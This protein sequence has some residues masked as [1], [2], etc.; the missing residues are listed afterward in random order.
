MFEDLMRRSRRRICSHFY[1]D[2]NNN[3]DASVFVAGSG[4]SGTS[5]LSNI[6]NHLNEFRYIFEPFAPAQ[7]RAFRHFNV[8]QYLRPSN[9]DS[10]FIEPV[11]ALLEGRLRNQWADHLNR[12]CISKKR[13]IKEIRASLFIK[14]LVTH[15]SEVPIV[16]ILRHPCAVVLSQLKTQWWSADSDYEQALGQSDLVEDFLGT[17]I[18]ELDA[19]SSAFERLIGLWCVENIVPLTQ[20]APNEVH[21]IFYEHLC[22]QPETE[23]RR[24]FSFLGLR[25]DEAKLANSLK[26]PSEL[27]GSDSAIV[28]GAHRAGNWLEKIPRADLN[29][30]MEILRLFGLE[31]IYGNGMQPLVSNGEDALKLFS[32]ST[33]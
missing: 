7:V 10:R 5:W 9:N 26:S 22:T 30:A 19:L 8:R 31:K 27:A 32:Q 25:S 24:L 23:T 14:W 6:I 16:F 18:R 4:R 3:I 11:H 1:F 21:L 12:R 17:M 13:L 33:R 29:R 20:L 15:F 28:K 2:L